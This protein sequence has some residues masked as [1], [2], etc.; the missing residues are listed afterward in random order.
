[1]IQVI[2]Y[3][4]NEIVL[5]TIRGNH[6]TFATSE[7]GAKEAPIDGLK[8]SKS[9]VENEFPDLKDNP[10]WKNIALER[11]KQKIKELPDEDAVANYII[12]DLRKYGYHPKYKQKQGFRRE[13]IK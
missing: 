1:M 9:G 5:V 6:I 4:A 2:F 13:A 10:E 11:F 12:S 8:L 7:Y 3:F